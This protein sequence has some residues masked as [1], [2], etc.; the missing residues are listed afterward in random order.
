MLYGRFLAQGTLTDPDGIPDPLFALPGTVNW[1]HAIAL[2]LKT[3]PI[4]FA[5]ARA[6]YGSTLRRTFTPQE[7]NSVFEHLLFAVHQ[8]SALEALRTVQRRSDVARVAI[9]TW[10]YGIY[11]AA[12]AMVAAQDGSLQDDH[13]GTA[14]CWDNQFAARGLVMPPFE[15]RVSTLLENSMKAEISALRRGN[16]FDLKAPATNAADARGALCAYLSGNVAYYRWR[17]EEDLR[18]TKEFKAL[19]VTNFK[20]KAARQLRDDRLN[21]RALSFLH[22]AFRYRGKANYREALYLGYG[23]NVETLVANYIDQLTFVLTGFV[24][25]AGA[26]TSKRIPPQLWSDF[27]SDIEKQRSFS[28][29][30]KSLWT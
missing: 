17:I 29:S 28:S 20:T 21:K 25:M 14:R 13:A 12:T 10:Y 8:V 6:F 18:G 24:I 19:N 27:V 5:A 3:T 16:T 30:P 22:L 2:L 26:F 4:D 11:A 23:N 7:E 1:M 15:L 9:I